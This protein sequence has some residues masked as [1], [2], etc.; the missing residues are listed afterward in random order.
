VPG[1]PQ[2]ARIAETNTRLTSIHST[3]PGAKVEIQDYLSQNGDWLSLGT[4]PLEHIRIPAGYFRWRISKPGIGEFVTAPKTD[5]GMEFALGPALGAQPGMVPVPGGPFGDMID[6]TGVLDDRLPA[7]DI[8]RFEVTNRQYQEF[9]DRGGYQKREY[10]KEKFIR[11]GKT[12]T[13]EQAMELFRDPTGRPGPSTWEAGHFPQG[14]AEYPVS[15]VSWYEAA[16]YAAF[17]GKN[18]PAILQWYKVAP[19]DLAAYSINHSNFGE[20]GLLPVGASGGLGPYG[21]YDM[22]GNVREWCLNAVDGDRRFILGGAW[23]TQTYQAYDPE[24]LDPFDRSSLNGF[25][26]VRNKGVLPASVSAPLVRQSRDFSKAKPASNEVFQVYQ[27]M[28]AYGNRPLNAKSEGVVETT[29]DWTKEKITIDAGYEQER[30]PIYLFLPKNVRPPYQTVVFYPSARV[31]TMSSSQNLGDLTFVDYVIKSG[32]A[33]VYPIY[34]DTYERQRGNSDP[35]DFEDRARVIMESKEV[36][37]SVD[38]LQTRPDID[39]SRL[40]Y[41][42]VSQGTAYGIIF[43][44]L[45]D[46]FKVVVFLDGGFFLGPMLPG[47][48]QVDFAPRLKKP[49]LMVNGRYDFTFSPDRA[50]L[51]M[52]RMIGTPDADKKRVVFDT[53]HDISQQKAELS[54]EVLAWLDKYLGRVN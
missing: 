44:A 28:Y 52:F 31:N 9:V 24:A 53:P 38:Y 5:E 12:L 23:R 20:R 34:Q 32:R 39:K 6:F 11:D 50:Q 17:A 4:T 35:G 1:D 13:W 2:L 26:C 27:T 7:F 48:D 54:K 37:R 46:R 30:L 47:R 42:G 40:G 33:L 25:R 29:S 19:S 18:L 45:E 41:L 3:P 8:D 15:G 49:V 14:Q 36:R 21:T 16:A 10:W 51:P 22:H 43:T